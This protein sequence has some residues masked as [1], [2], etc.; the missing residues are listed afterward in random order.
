[1]PPTTFTVTVPAVVM[2]LAGTLAVSSDE[3]TKV[4]FSAKPFHWM[5]SPELNPLPFTASVNAGPP[6]TAELGF[7]TIAAELI[8]NVRV[9][10]GTPPAVTKTLTLPGVRTSLAGICTTTCVAD[11]EVGTSVMLLND[12][13]VTD[14]RLLPVMVSGNDVEPAVTELGF[15]GAVML[16]GGLTVNLAV[17]AILP[18]TAVTVTVPAVAMSLAGTLAV[19]CEDET[20]VVGSGAPFH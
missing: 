17:G 12:T 7:S 8:V 15:S 16:G 10:E 20:K 11:T 19:N 1:M 3:E 6:A 13:E 4:V 14:A 5:N 2:S 9:F 18:V